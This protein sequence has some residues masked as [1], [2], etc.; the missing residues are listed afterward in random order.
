MTINTQKS[1]RRF[2]FAVKTFQQGMLDLDFAA[3][4]PADNVMMVVAC[5]L[6]AQMTIAGLGG[7]HDP[8]LCQ[9][10]E[11]AIH[12]RFGETRQLTLRLLVHFAWGEVRAGVS[13]HVQDRRSLRGHSE[14]T[15]A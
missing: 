15:G 2:Q 8:I 6:V 5:D 7:T 4:D 11:R 1:A 14:P 3:T 10:F 13:Q 12:G 9:E